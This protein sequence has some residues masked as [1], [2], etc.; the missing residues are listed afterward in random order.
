MLVLSEAQSQSHTV[1]S[2]SLEIRNQY[3]LLTKTK[4]GRFKCKINLLPVHAYTHKNVEQ[5][6]YLHP[7]A[8][9]KTSIPRTKGPEPGTLHEQASVSTYAVM[10]D[11]THFSN[12]ESQVK[13]PKGV[14]LHVHSKKLMLLIHQRPC[15]RSETKICKLP[16]SSTAV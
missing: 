2:K 11:H 15:H 13:Y 3:Q 14:V 8:K 9:W 10:M 6:Q 4:A 16:K 5:A 12:L 7:R 1:N